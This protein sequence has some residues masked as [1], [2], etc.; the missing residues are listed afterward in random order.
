VGGSCGAAEEV[1]RPPCVA[2][3]PS[4][5]S[6]FGECWLVLI[7][8]AAPT[9]LKGIVD[10]EATA[11]VQFCCSYATFQSSALVWVGTG[12]EAPGGVNCET[13]S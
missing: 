10:A 11:A 8:E 7:R 12:P 13:T 5:S 3:V 1:S 9:I 4:E 6:P 2:A